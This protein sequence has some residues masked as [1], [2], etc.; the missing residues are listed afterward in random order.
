M[1]F[2][3]LDDGPIDLWYLLSF[4]NKTHQNWYFVFHPLEK[5]IEKLLHIFIYHGFDGNFIFYRSVK[6]WFQ[7]KCSQNMTILDD[8]ES[9]KMNLS[10]LQ[11]PEE[12]SDAELIKILTFVSWYFLP[13]YLIAL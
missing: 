10:Q 9:H 1:N 8:E 7:R 3:H 4:Y 6:H 12:L 5:E 2:F 11:R 13:L